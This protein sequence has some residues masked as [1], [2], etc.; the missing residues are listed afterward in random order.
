M[1]EVKSRPVETG[2]TGPVTTAPLQIP[3]IFPWTVCD[4]EI[5]VQVEFALPKTYNT[6]KENA[7][8]PPLT[9]ILYSGHLIIQDKMLRSGLNL[10]YA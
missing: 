6:M 9:D 10:H 8:E 7:V 1:G 3:H 4:R 5:Q 2:L